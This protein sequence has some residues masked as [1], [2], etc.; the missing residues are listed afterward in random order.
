MS[1]VQRALECARPLLRQQVQCEP[2]GD[3]TQRPTLQLTCLKPI[4]SK[5]VSVARC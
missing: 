3:T 2:G 1:G 5:D 4:G